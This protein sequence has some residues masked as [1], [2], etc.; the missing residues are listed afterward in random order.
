MAQFLTVASRGIV[1]EDENI[2][3]SLFTR[4]NEADSTVKVLIGSRKFMEGWDSFRVSSMGLMN[5]G[6]GEGAQI[7]QLFG[8]GVRL[9]GKGLSLKRSSA[10]ESDG[11]PPHI[12]RLETLN[13]FGVCANYMAQFREYL[14]Q[15]GIE[16]GF[17]EMHLPIRVRDDFLKAGLQVLRLPEDERFENRR[18]VVLTA[19]GGV[20]VVLDLRPRLE[21][22]KSGPSEAETMEKAA[23]ED[24]ATV[25]RQYAPLFDWE[26]MYFDLLTFKRLKGYHNLSF[27]TASLRGILENGSYQ[28][29]CPDGQLP[30]SSFREVRR[31]E[32]IAIAVLQKYVAAFY[33][34]KRRAWEDEHLRLAALAPNDPNFTF[35]D[36]GV[37]V[38]RKQSHRD[39]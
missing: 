15:E 19:G 4:I 35:G 20:R 30:P 9:W 1:R 21:L 39:N 22:A 8:R 25:L 26:R 11:A 29:L 13:V 3:G 23:G 14:K 33:D 12:R 17:E 28:V 7:I 18:G 31:A 5:I 2:S 27:G 24:K 10:L 34:R 32:D 36:G 37:F 6:K 38:N 16:T